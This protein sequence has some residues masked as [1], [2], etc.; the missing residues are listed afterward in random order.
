[1]DNVQAIEIALEAYKSPRAFRVS[2]RVPL[3]SGMLTLIKL[4]ATTPEDV[5]TLVAD[6]TAEQLPVRDAAIFYL[7]QIL[8]NAQDDLRQLA[9]NDDATLQ[10]V[11]DHKRWLLKWLHPDRNPNSWE[12]ALFHRV[13]A[14]SARLEASLREGVPELK[15]VARTHSRR[16][17]PGNW[18]VAQR[19]VARTVGWRPRLIKLAL[20]TILFVIFVALAQISLTLMQGSQSSWALSAEVLRN[21]GLATTITGANP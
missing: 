7:Q 15:S 14:A 13:N 16:R 17:T 18:Q 4:A 6:E 1:M 5:R 2:R 10:D 21:D 12:S 20:A 19:R 8:S 3:P 9:L 11:K